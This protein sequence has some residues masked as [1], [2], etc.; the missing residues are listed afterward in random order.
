M[1]RREFI[2][3]L[4]GAAAWPLAA[5][6][7][8]PA[9]PVIGFLSTR[10]CADSTR[11]TEAFREGLAG[12]GRVEGRNIA[13]EYRWA[14]G[15]FDRLSTLATELVRRPVSALAT[16]GGNQSAR[17]AKATTTTIPI[18]FGIGEDPIEVG[19]VASLN[20]PS[21]NITGATFSTSLLGA[22]RLGLLRELVPGADLIALFVN[23]NASQGRRK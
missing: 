20:R 7:Q 23:A 16:V 14:E 11:V 21:G 12:T 1:R 5:Q 2:L 3:A 4:G 6:A 22:K 17:A 8:Q 15:Q 13:I 18:V 9:M 19:L 10:S